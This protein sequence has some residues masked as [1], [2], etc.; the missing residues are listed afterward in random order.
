M[1]WTKKRR[2]ISEYPFVGIV[3][4]LIRG[5]FARIKTRNLFTDAFKNENM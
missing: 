5:N 2:K 3:M 1:W 4:L